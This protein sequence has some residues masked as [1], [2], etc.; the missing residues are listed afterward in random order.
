MDIDGR[1]VDKTPDYI[2]LPWYTN[3]GKSLNW[4]PC[5]M[6]KGT[7]NEIFHA[8]FQ[9]LVNE[10]YNDHTTDNGGETSDIY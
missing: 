8:E 6:R 10:K 7:P 4:S 5:K 3:D 9:E 1:K 2:R